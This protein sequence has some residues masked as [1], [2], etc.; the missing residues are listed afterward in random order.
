MRGVALFNFSKL[1]N[2]SS[3]LSSGGS[4]LACL[5]FT[6][7]TPFGFLEVTSF[8]L[9]SLFSVSVLCIFPS[10]GDPKSSGLISLWSLISGVEV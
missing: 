6:C 8:V 5:T 7:S 2:S 4:S 9:I 10:K 1:S 3:E